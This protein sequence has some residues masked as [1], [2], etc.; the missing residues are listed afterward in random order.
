M[1]VTDRAKNETVIRFSIDKKP[2]LVTGVENGKVYQQ[3]KPTFTEG[4]AKLNGVAYTS[5]TLIILEGN[6]VLIVTDQA[7]NE[8]KISFT[9]PHQSP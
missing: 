3:V 5:G 9:T 7:G 1:K 2:V 8:T 4:T 6:H